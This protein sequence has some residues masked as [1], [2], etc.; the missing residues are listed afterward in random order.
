MTWSP[1]SCP[2][3]DHRRSA[4]M[5]H[6]GMGRI[7]RLHPIGLMLL[8]VWGG[9]L[10]S[11][12][13]R[14]VVR[15]PGSQGKFEVHGEILDQRGEEIT[16]RAGEDAPIQTFRGAE[17]LVV[18]PVRS[19]LHQEG[20]DLLSKDPVQAAQLLEQALGEETRAWVRRDILADLIKSAVVQREYPVA[21]ARYLALET[22]DPETRYL[23]VIPLRW[24]RET[25]S[26]ED[27]AAALKWLRSRS[28]TA[29]L[30]GASQLLLD[31]EAASDAQA[32]LRQ[33][34]RGDSLRLQPLAQWQL[35]RLE[36]FS[37][38]PRLSDLQYWQTA[39]DQLPAHLQAGPAFLVAE[40]LDRRSETTLA[41]SYW[42]RLITL[43][44][45]DLRLAAEALGR[46][47]ASLRRLGQ[48]A[49][50]DKLEVELHQR[51]PAFSRGNDPEVPGKNVRSAQGH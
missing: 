51:F 46:S 4:S 2:T 14:L 15:R 47:V 18:E 34:S 50:A 6:R 13:D 32:A 42:L 24:T 3:L 48:S 38:Q 19:Q 37:G 45:N 28:P 9:G 31:S 5:V 11:A 26:R 17:I 35:R 7:C 41:T 12:D 40:A 33:I 49:E 16:F 21:G 30:L 1:L 44:S 10:A 36:A 22:S 27:R 20:R 25:P 8:V 23:A 29:Q 43:E 39:L